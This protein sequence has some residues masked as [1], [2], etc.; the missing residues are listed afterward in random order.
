MKMHQKTKKLQ[1]HFDSVATEKTLEYRRLPT[2]QAGGSGANV[3]NA[4]CSRME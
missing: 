3:A 2:W 1:L 4:G